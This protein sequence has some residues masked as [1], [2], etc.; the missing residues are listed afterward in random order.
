MAEFDGTIGLQCFVVASFQ[1]D[2]GTLTKFIKRPPW[3]LE[4]P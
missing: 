3:F 2:F 4:L 1:V